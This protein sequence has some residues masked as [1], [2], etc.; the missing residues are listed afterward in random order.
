MTDDFETT[1]GVSTSKNIFGPPLLE[2]NGSEENEYDVVV[3]KIGYSNKL[4]RP[5]Y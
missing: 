3:F 1:V 2:N 5:N 4:G